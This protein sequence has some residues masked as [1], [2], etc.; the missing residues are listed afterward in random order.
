MTGCASHH[1]K[2]V[3]FDTVPP[4]TLVSAMSFV[5]SHTKN[6]NPPNKEAVLSELRASHILT[7]RTKVV[8]I[9]WNRKEQEWHVI[10]LH[11]AG[12]RTQWRTDATAWRIDGGSQVA[13]TAAKP[14][15]ESNSIPW[16]APVR[17]N[18]SSQ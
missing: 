10:L 14:S 13:V 17:Y 4:N 8:S 5:D 12:L 11:P 1:P 9:R 7:P 2:A 15:T 16:S 18:P 3:N 6:P